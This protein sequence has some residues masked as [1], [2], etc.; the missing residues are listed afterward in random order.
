MIYWLTFFGRIISAT[1]ETASYSIESNSTCTPSNWALKTGPQLPLPAVCLPTNS[2]G[3][4][5]PSSAS[6]VL[7]RHPPQTFRRGETFISPL[8]SISFISPYSPRNMT[9]L[10][11]RK[12][13]SSNRFLDRMFWLKELHFLRWFPKLLD[14]VFQMS[15]LLLISSSRSRR[16]TS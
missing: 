7:H 11:L 12:V 10:I 1:W 13:R 2:T 5:N 6:G 14:T 9:R 16:C 4:S 8:K 15:R 3:F